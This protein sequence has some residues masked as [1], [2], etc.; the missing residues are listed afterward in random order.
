MTGIAGLPRGAYL[1]SPC[2]GY[3]HLLVRERY[4]RTPGWRTLC[5]PDGS[6]CSGNAGMTEF[7]PDYVLARWRRVEL[8]G[9]WRSAPPEDGALEER[10]VHT[11]IYVRRE[12][13][14]TGTT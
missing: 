12:L 13:R 10:F 6:P 5:V 11:G 3:A 2:G 4:C 9:V 7:I 8:D 1:R 14:R